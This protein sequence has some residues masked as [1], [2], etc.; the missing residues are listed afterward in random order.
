MIHRQFL[1]QKLFAAMMA[2]TGAPFALPPLARP[3]LARLLPF[4]SNLLLSDFNKETN[5]LHIRTAELYLYNLS[6]LLK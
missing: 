4:A 3:Q 2:N 5:G 1:W 6:R